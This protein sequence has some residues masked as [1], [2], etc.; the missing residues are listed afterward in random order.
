MD[1]IFR[2]KQFDILQSDT[3]MKVNTDG[4]LLGAWTEVEEGT[5]I[6]DIG[7]GTGLI[8]LILA[9]RSTNTVIDAI[10]IDNEAFATAQRNVSNSPFSDRIQVIHQA[11]QTFVLHADKRYD[12]IISNPPFFESN[13]TAVFSKLASAKHTLHLSHEALLDAV[14]KVLTPSGHFDLI[15]PYSEGLNLM[16]LAKKYKLFPYKITEVIPKAN[17]GVERLLIGLKFNFRE[18]C[19][20]EVLVLQQSHHAND[21]TEE[22][23][24]L[25]KEFYLFL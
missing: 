18:D 5:K 12:H 7:T 6:L 23:K 3:I 9:Q 8:A 10:E 15:L 20:N 19:L 14:V 16:E 2:F 24:N 22:Y 21:Y 1:Q 4:I 11:V 13:K 25:V 17:K